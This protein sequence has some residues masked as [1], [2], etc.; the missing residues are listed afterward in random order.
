LEMSSTE[1]PL[2]A[3]LCLNMELLPLLSG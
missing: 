2:K 3:L 1:K